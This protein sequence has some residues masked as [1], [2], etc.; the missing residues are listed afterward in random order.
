MLLGAILSLILLI[1]TAVLAHAGHGE[2]F[3]EG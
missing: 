2:Q 3:Q 1:P